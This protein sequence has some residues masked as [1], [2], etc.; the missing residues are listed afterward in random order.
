MRSR[1]L[2]LATGA[3]AGEHLWP[4]AA[5]SRIG[6]RVNGSVG[7]LHFDVRKRRAAAA[8]RADNAAVLLDSDQCYR[9]LVTHD[10]QR[11]GV[12]RLARSLNL[13]ILNALL[14]VERDRRRPPFRIPDSLRSTGMRQRARRGRRVSPDTG[15]GSI[16]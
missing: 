8:R 13:L 14:D 7:P 6:N 10:A 1:A 4:S 2:A 9:A 3:P 5:E 15:F 12:G 16:G 11:V